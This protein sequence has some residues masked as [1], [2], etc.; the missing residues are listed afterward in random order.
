L[1]IEKLNKVYLIYGIIRGIKMSYDYDID[2]NKTFYD[3]DLEREDGIEKFG[4]MNYDKW[5]T[6]FEEE[7]IEEWCELYPNEVP[8]DD[9]WDTIPDKNSFQS[10]VDDEYERYLENETN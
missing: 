1:K 10:Y 3:P 2:G 9:Y 5:Y 6:L 4:L 7:L 8:L